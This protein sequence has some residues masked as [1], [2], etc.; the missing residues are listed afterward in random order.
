[1]LETMR[2]RTLIYFSYLLTFFLYVPSLAYAATD[3]SSDITSDTEWTLDGSPYVVD[4]PSNPRS[5]HF[6]SIASGATLVVDPGVVVKLGAYNGI[7]VDGVLRAEGSAGNPVIFTSLLDDSAGGDT[8]GDGDATLPE[9]EQWSHLEFNIGSSGTFEYAT[10]RYGGARR[11]L[12]GPNTGIANYGGTVSINHTTLTHNGYDGL[13]QHGGR[14]TI[15]NSVISNQTVG[16]D[17]SGGELEIHN[18][19]IIDNGV[20]IKNNGET[21]ADARDTWWGD[22]SGP[23]DEANNSTGAGNGVTGDVVYSPW[24]TSDPFAEP[25]PDPCIAAGTCVSNVLFLPGIEGSRL[26]RPM[27]GCDPSTSDCEEHKLWD[28]SGDGDLGD[29]SLDDAG[30]SVRDDVYVK[31]GDIV[32]SASMFGVTKKFYDG[33]IAQMDELKTDGAMADW[34]PVAYDWRLSLPDLLNNGAERD[35]K[36]YY[37]EATSTPY[38]EQTLRALASSSKTG[39]VTLIA[40][41]NGGLLAKALIKKLGEVAAKELIDDVILVGVPQSGAPQAVGGLLFGYGQALPRDDCSQLFL[42]GSLCSSL[43]SRAAARSLAEHSPMAY[44]LLPSDTYFASTQDPWHSVASFTGAHEYRKEQEAYGTT[45]DDF[46]ELSDFLQ[47]KE[48]GR[49][50]PSPEDTSRPGILNGALLEYAKGEHD[51]LDSWVPPSGITLYQIAGWGVDTISG[52]SFYEDQ[53]LFGLLGTAPKY[54][55]IFVEDGD[56]VVPVPSA[57]L[58]STSTENV[59]RYWIDLANSSTKHSNLFENTSLGTF[60]ENVLTGAES[61]LPATISTTAPIVSSTKKLIFFLHSPLTLQLEDSSGNVT[62]IA[63]DGSISQDISGSTYGEF[64]EVKYLIAPAD[65]QY[66]LTLHG[67]DSGTF[68]LDIQESSG[69]VVTAST[70]IANVPTTANTLASLTISDGLDT[71]SAL[72]VDMNGDGEDVVT[73]APKIGETVLYTAPA[74]E[75]DSPAPSRA[76]G[77]PGYSPYLPIEETSTATTSSQNLPDTTA[78]PPVEATTTTPVSVIPATTIPIAVP[79]KPHKTEAVVRAPEQKRETQSPV[80]IANSL[81]DFSQTASVYGVSQQPA[82]QRFGMAVYNALHGFWLALMQF[83]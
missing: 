46:S 69:G 59:K 60:L 37:E 29:L 3:V 56:G 33:L 51:T 36:I 18:S 19:S 70:T 45:I 23:Y 22:A 72:T 8:N 79:T 77:G 16:I 67:Q 74:A 76:A 44:H 20:G 41:S 6:L 2:V 11:I 52:I 1:M 38:I 80:A 28:P 81:P 12:F 75:E 13:G 63:E 82:L 73:I 40:H 55:P 9:D 48:G 65:S 49:T 25:P 66:Q 24:L 4:F 54:R 58:T 34:R 53:R 42:V 31:E 30:K 43:A 14:T 27:D 50:S 62:G 71:V 7:A 47:A 21:S 32:G 61:S 78:T 64:G 10:V 17:M 26:Y 35:G 39:K 5:P 83:L 68:S 15:A 57:L